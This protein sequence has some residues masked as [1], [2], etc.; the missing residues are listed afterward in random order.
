VEG[1]WG[2]KAPPPDRYYDASYHQKA[3]ALANANAA[4]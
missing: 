1:S 4:K 3:L 2:G